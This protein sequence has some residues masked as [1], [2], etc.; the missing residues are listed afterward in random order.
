MQKTRKQ[1]NHKGIFTPFTRPITERE[2]TT[3][4]EVV[5][6]IFRTIHGLREIERQEQ[7]DA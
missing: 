2:E 7:H 4:R 3:Q 6:Q 5:G 1:D